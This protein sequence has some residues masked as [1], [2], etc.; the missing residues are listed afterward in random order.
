VAEGNAAEVISTEGNEG[1]EGGQPSGNE[2][3]GDGTATG[4]SAE[5]TENAGTNNQ[6]DGGEDENLAVEG[7]DGKKYIPY[8]AFKARIDAL[9]AKKYGS[10]ETFLEALDKDPDFAKTVAEKLNG[11]AS[12]TPSKESGEPT[13]FEKFLAPLPPQHQAHYRGMIG[14]VAQEFEGYVNEYVKEQLGPIMDYIGK[15]KVENFARQNKDFGKYQKSVETIMREGRAK[16]IEDAF[17]L[18]SYE[19]RIKNVRQAGAK[20][21]QER[22]QKIV[23]APVGGR[24]AGGAVTK[25][26]KVL[27]RRAALLKAAEEAGY[28][29]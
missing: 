2:G 26:G 6:P 29:D 27:D 15:S 25:D 20:E 22:R 24:S 17:I 8:E 5:N 1:T 16:S 10:R 11:G 13:P 3:Q 12:A 14:A 28:T 23:R 7:E 18:A 9:T 21:E 4:G 19:D